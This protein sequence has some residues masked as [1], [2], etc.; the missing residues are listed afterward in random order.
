MISLPRTLL[1]FSACLCLLLFACQL[2]LIPE[3]TPT[4][5]PQPIPTPQPTVLPTPSGADNNQQ[6]MDELQSVIEDLR[7]QL[8]ENQ[9]ETPT[10][11][12]PSNA[13]SQE[14]ERLRSNLEE[15]INRIDGEQQPSTPSENDQSTVIERIIK[16]TASIIARSGSGTGVIIETDPDGSALLLTNE[17]VTQGGQRITAQINGKKYAATLIGED[18]RRDLALIRICC[19][20]DWQAV[21]IANSKDVKQG[22]SVI[23]LGY[24]LGSSLGNEV[25][26]TKGTISA[27]RYNNDAARW[28]IQTDAA[29]NPGNSGGPLTLDDGRL[30]GINTY[31]VET[32]S[33]GRPVTGINFAVAS[34]TFQMIVTEFKQQVAPSLTVELPPTPSPSPTAIPIQQTK[35]S[36]WGPYEGSIPLDTSD[37]FIDEFD[38]NVIS[39]DF[40]LDSVFHNPYSRRVGSWSVGFLFRSSGENNF[41]SFIITSDASW[42]HIVRVGNE[43]TD[44]TVAKG[45]ATV[46]DT[47]AN[48]YNR[49]QMVI[50]GESGWVVVNGS[51]IAE[52]DLA[53][54]TEEGSIVAVSSFFSGDGVQGESV[55]YEGFSINRM[56]NSYSREFG[57]V[58]NTSERYIGQEPTYTKIA[59]GVISATFFNPA[60]ASEHL[61]D[62]GFIFNGSVGDGDSGFDVLVF[63]N[64]KRW[65]HGRLVPGS[66]QYI[67]VAVGSLPYLETGSKQQNRVRLVI[68]GDKAL[69]FVNELFIDSLPI[70]TGELGGEVSIITGYYAGSQPVG[71]KVD[72]Q[73]FSIWKAR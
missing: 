63:E 32:T 59:E 9:N 64:R 69:M 16:S 50:L 11:E 37:S 47:G 61:W 5:A 3:P 36:D 29:I 4:L 41:H 33:G 39:A 13:V 8:A 55:R 49:I 22:S 40:T 72:F 26:V 19:D 25:T 73:N 46:I 56:E 15:L 67:E 28:E 51:Y 66:R 71:V 42:H 58:E 27:R 70:N 7:R 57:T 35:E 48:G 68:M 1:L 20:V 53:D 10:V 18:S 31:R 44:R 6:E 12:P 62:Y 14:I 52:L 21:P 2:P 45:M 30:V 38:P 43:S 24:P 60:N 17:H 23:A 34:E 54:I 65:H